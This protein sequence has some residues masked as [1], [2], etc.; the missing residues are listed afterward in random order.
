MRGDRMRDAASDLAGR[1]W[2]LFGLTAAEQDAFGR[3]NAAAERFFSAPP[4]VRARSEWAGDGMWAGYQPMPAGD[5]DVLDHVDRFETTR[6]AM[7]V[8]EGEWPW[9]S[10]QACR[11]R[12]ALAEVAAISAALVSAAVREVSLNAGHDAA[13]AQALWCEDDES[14]LVVNSYR[15]GLGRGGGTVLNQTVLNQTVLNQTVLN[16]TVLNQTVLN[17]T[18]L[19]QT[20]LNETVVKMKPHADFGGLSLIFAAA[21]LESLEFEADGGWRPVRVP[22]GL[23]GRAGV[24]LIGQLFAHWLGTEAPVHRVVQASGGRRMS[25]VYFHQPGLDAVIDGPDGVPVV[26]GEHIAAMQAYY[27]GLGDPAARR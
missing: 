7:A 1:G 19:N 6:Q 9:R 21:G 4:E 15:S 12:R 17:Q 10:D 22:A 23:A 18:V 24:I 14:T 16:Q 3:L 26:A 8:G 27:N 13:K 5:P 11:L 25:T 2:S 20:V